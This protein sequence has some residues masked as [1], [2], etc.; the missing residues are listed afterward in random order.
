MDEPRLELSRPLFE[1]PPD[2]LNDNSTWGFLVGGMAWIEGELP[3]D[4]FMLAAE[5]LVARALS[6]ADESYR[7]MAPILYLYRHA[8]EL[9]LKQIVRPAKPTHN[10]AHLISELEGIMKRDYQQ[11]L[12]EPVRAWL[13][14]WATQ[15]PRSTT[16]RYSEGSVGTISGEWWVD[17]HHLR[18]VMTFLA[19]N[20]KRMRER[21]GRS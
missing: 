3:A 4:E 17:M 10:L 14:E 15:D 12:P 19:E 18:R 21:R 5:A 8:L 13:M 11:T 16:F 9:Y 2:D 7:Y 20:F 6:E 1:E